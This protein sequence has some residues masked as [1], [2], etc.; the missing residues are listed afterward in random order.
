ME[1]NKELD[2]RGLHCP[3]PIL[4]TKKALADMLSGEVLRVMA[5]DSGSVRDFQAFA[6]Q[7]GNDL[8]EQSE[9]NKEF[10]FFMKRK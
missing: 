6:K 4:K 9:E 10:I 8:L 3:L 1:F 5:T 7:T 2:A